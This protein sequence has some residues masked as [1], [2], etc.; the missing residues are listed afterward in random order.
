MAKRN[1]NETYD[2]SILQ[3]SPLSEVRIS[4]QQH[5]IGRTLILPSS[6]G[7]LMKRQRATFPELLFMF[8]L[9]SIFDEVHFLG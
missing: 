2:R 8:L 6:V 4:R 1:D 9:L 7:Q 5:G 3:C